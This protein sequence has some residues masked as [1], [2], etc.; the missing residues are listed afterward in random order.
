MTQPGKAQGPLPLGDG[1]QGG[2]TR[3]PAPPGGEPLLEA[4]GITK[5]F[6]GIRAL[7][8][9]DLDVRPG[10]CVGLIGPN[11]A[12]KSTF[13]DCLT[14][15]LVP[16][17]G[18][19]RFRGQLLDGRSGPA[20]ARLGMAR[21]FQ[22]SE[23]FAGMTVADHLLVAIQARSGRA[24]VWRDLAGQG[25]P[26]AVETRRAEEVLALVGLAGHRDRPVES[27]T[28]GQARLVE[29]G[30]ALACDPVLLFLDEPS[31]GLDRDEAGAVAAVLEGV[32]DRSGTA[33]LLTEHDVPFVRR[34]A[35]RLY[36]LDAGQVLAEGPTGEV[37]ADPAVRAAYL[38]AGR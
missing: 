1:D 38:G 10:E 3:P 9:V 37:L 19:V 7:S 35:T 11:G 23:L 27:L 33:I 31:S 24:R 8:A 18:Q 5:R 36:V 2:G 22:R 25:R 16:D 32:R 20:R 6:D 4:R 34:L 14:G 13:F 28:L 17:A 21:T 12:G 29:L 30:R 26:T 15:R